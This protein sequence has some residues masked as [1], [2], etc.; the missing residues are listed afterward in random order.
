MRN[1]SEVLIHFHAESPNYEVQVSKDGVNYTSIYHDE[2]GTQGDTVMRQISFAPQDV[3]YV[4]YVQNKMW[5]H[6]SNGKFYGSSISEIEVFEGFLIENIT[7]AEIS[8]VVSKDEEFKLKATILPTLAQ[9]KEVVYSSNDSSVASVDAIGEVKA[10]S[11]GTTTLKIASKENP[12]IFAEKTITVVNGPI[13]AMELRFESSQIE[14][15]SRDKRYLTYAVYP[16]NAINQDIAVTWSSSNPEVVSVNQNGLIQAH[17]KGDAII[18]VVSKEDAN[19]S[20]S[21]QVSIK[22]P[23]YS[24]NYDIMKDRWIRRVVGENLNMEDEDIRNYV[25]NI[26]QEADKLWSSMHKEEGRTTLWDKLASDTVSA[27]YTTQFTKIKKIALAYGIEGTS[28]YQNKELLADIVGAIDF[29]VVNKKYNGIYSTGNW[30]DWQ[31]GCTQPLVDTLMIIS[32]YTEYSDI[33]KAVKSIEGYAK[34]PSTQWPSYTATGANRTDIGLS[35][36]GSAILAKSDARMNLVKSEVPDVMKLVTSGDGLYKDGSLIQHTKHAYTGSYG[37]E[38]L[39]GVGKIQSI[40]TGTQFDIVDERMNNVYNTILNGYI[41]LMHKGQMMSM[42]NGRSI[43]RAPGTNPFTTEFEA[44]SETISNVMLIAQFAPEEY[45]GVFLSAIK[46]WLEVETDD[47]DF[48]AHARDFDALLD[49]K[50]ILEDETITSSTYNGM[51]VYGSMDRVV[52]VKDDYSVGLSMYSSRI[53][54]YEFGNTE[55]KKGWHT[56]SGVLYLYNNDLK[57]YGEGYWPTIDPYRLPGTTVDT[58]E[59]TDGAGNNKTSPQS[60]VGGASDGEN[61][62]SA[63]FYNSTNTGLGMDLKAQKSWFF[64]DGKIVALGAGINGTSD[65]SIE[66]TV[67]NRMLTGKNNTVSLNGSTWNADEEDKN[68]KSGDY[69]HLQGTGTGNDIGYYFLED[70]EV[71]MQKEERTGKYADINSYFVNDKTY[72]NT[73]FKMGVN[74]GNSAV[75]DTYEYV[76]LPGYTKQ[77]MNDYASNNTV[78]VIRNDAEVQALRDTKTGEFAFN[79]WTESTISVEGISVNNSASVYTKTKDGVLRIAISDPKQKNVKLTLTVDAYDEIISKDESVTVN[80]DGSFTIDTMKSAGASHEIVLKVESIS[81][82][83]LESALEKAKVISTQE[84]K[85]TKSSFSAFMDAYEIA[86]EVYKDSFVKQEH[87]DEVTLTLEKS[88][89]ALAVRASKESLAQLQTAKGDLESMEDGYSKQ[90]FA[91]ALENIEKANTLLQM[92]VE[93]VMQKQVDELLSI[94]I[95]EK[96]NLLVVTANKEV[97]IAI[98]LAQNILQSDS[99]NTIKP[100]DVERLKKAVADATTLVEASDITLSKL[101]DAKEALLS[102]IQKLEKRADKTSLQGLIADA[103]TLVENNYTTKSWGV[104]ATALQAAI[105][106]A[107]DS[108]VSGITVSQAQQTLFKAIKGL[109]VKYVPLPPIKGDG[110]TTKPKEDKKEV[111]KNNSIKKDEN[112]NEVIKNDTIKKEND[113]NDDNIKKESIDQTKVPTSKLEGEDESNNING[114]IATGLIVIFGLGALTLLSINRKR[115]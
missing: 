63:M 93:E 54:N 60:W 38:L 48:F 31:I 16:K 74:H 91:I 25:E 33:D 59:L 104:L 101:K 10:L 9:H 113:A 87:V 98:S 44:G 6:S 50:A 24:A 96:E 61:G 83:Q 3:R 92:S 18:R 62:V 86:Q 5:K 89:E 23:T 45:R 34:K 103:K 72:T 70:S 97:K 65:D 37:N 1:I 2:E 27:D 73:F 29:M 52:Q 107:N 21:L 67:E 112:K 57:Q 64:F 26:D 14:L 20:G 82:V 100:K 55:N 110:E 105:K 88:M 76:L 13:K 95:K 78:E 94:M 39:K 102:A 17:A 7:L 115:K 108:N 114:W 42:V 8:D 40:I 66:T 69:V 4:K 99:V 90:E 28:L 111:A 12:S 19:V 22:E 46:G 68:L 106:V 71:T 32:D 56:G 53:Y 30:W 43:S 58:K 51:Q 75:N 47:F 15:T 36:L 77:E 41:P 49:A 79:N 84:N 35:V 81:K 85:Y 11:A 109:E 80:D